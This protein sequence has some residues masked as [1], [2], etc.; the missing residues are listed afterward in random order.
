VDGGAALVIAGENYAK[1]NRRAA[2]G[3][4]RKLGL[5]RRRT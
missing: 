5:R 1:A 4:N 3:K 2:V